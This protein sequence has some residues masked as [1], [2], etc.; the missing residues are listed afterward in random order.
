MDDMLTLER[1]LSRPECATSMANLKGNAFV[2]RPLAGDEGERLAAYFAGLSPQTRGW[3]AP[4]KFD[5]ETA[6]AFCHDL[7][8][9]RTLRMV[10]VT[11]EPPAFAAY[12]LL[13]FGVR[14]AD[15]GRFAD[16]G[17]PLDGTADCTLAP[18]V[19]DAYQSVGLG[20]ALMRHV[21]DVARRAG[22]RRMVLF[23][24]VNADNLGAVHFYEKHG[25]RTVAMF[26]TNGHKHDMI[27]DLA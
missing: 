19:S 11:G 21:I 20:S 12:F 3:F 10:A 24:G 23:G 6:E 17:M 9:E 27:M 18:S 5:A 25:F 1:I 16:Y 4:H 8:S 15:A 7:L 13:Q 26:G 2:F 22:K 14:D